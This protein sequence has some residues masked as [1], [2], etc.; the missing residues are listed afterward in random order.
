MGHTGGVQF[1]EEFLEVGLVLQERGD[2]AVVAGAGH[3][4]GE[5]I[6]AVGAV[7]EGVVQPQPTTEIG[8]RA[9][10]HRGVLQS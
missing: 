7:G 9:R 1:L 8:H 4:E 5:S 6:A 3:E 10:L 2:V